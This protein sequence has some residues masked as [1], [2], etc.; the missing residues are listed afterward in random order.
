MAPGAGAPG[1][2]DPDAGALGE[3]DAAR[4][5]GVP[6]PPDPAGDR[7]TSI[8]PPSDGGVL[9]CARRNP[10]PA[11]MTSTAATEI[12]MHHLRTE[13]DMAATSHGATEPTVKAR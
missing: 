2:G 6:S 13:T 3:P 5:P 8:V 1:A 7:L 10:T 9:S 11:A 12:P 4:P